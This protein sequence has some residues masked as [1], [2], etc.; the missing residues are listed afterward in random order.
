MRTADDFHTDEQMQM[1]MA[2]ADL[3]D[4]QVV[5]DLRQIYKALLS[6]G[7]RKPTLVDGRWK[8]KG[9]GS[10]LLHHQLIGLGWMLSRE[11]QPT[12]PRGGILS[13]EMG[14]GKTVEFLACMSQNP[15]ARGCKAKQTLILA[16]KRLLD[17][18]WK[19]IEKHCSSTKTTRVFIY[20]ASHAGHCRN[21]EKHAIM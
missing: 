6:F 17:Q 14:L 7:P 4:P 15:P 2:D 5:E 9:F 18:W 12:V 1:L 8:I 16:P 10:P 13:D 3:S 20:E 11:R 19:E 21:W